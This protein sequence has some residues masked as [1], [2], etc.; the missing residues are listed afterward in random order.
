MPKKNLKYVAYHEAGHAVMCFHQRVAVRGATIVPDEEVGGRVF[1]ANPLKGVRLDIETTTRSRWQME[2]LVRVCLA[3]PEAQR[4]YS[5]RSWR[6]AHGSD[7]FSQAVDLLGYF[8]GS[9]EEIEAYLHLLRVQTRQFLRLPHVWQAVQSVAE[10]LLESKQLG[11]YEL[12]QL[13]RNAMSP[14]LPPS[15]LA[16]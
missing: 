6:N 10:A 16:G 5:P 13:I 3:G 12:R 11:G 8:C 2:K 15:V 9:S 1:H 7:D 14:P 4:R